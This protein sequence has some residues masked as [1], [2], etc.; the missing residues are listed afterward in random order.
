N[1]IDYDAFG[2]ILAQSDANVVTVAYYTGRYRDLVTGLQYDRARWYHADTGRW[3]SEDPI[4]F[5]AG[6]ANLYRYVGNRPVFN[7]DPRGL[8]EPSW[9]SWIRMRSSAGNIRIMRRWYKWHEVH[10]FWE[11]NPEDEGWKGV[12][13]PGYVRRQYHADRAADY[14][15]LVR[16]EYDLTIGFMGYDKA[17]GKGQSGK[18]HL[19]GVFSFEGWRNLTSDLI[20][21]YQNL[22]EEEDKNLLVGKP[23]RKTYYLQQACKRCAST[24][25]GGAK[26]QQSFFTSDPID[27]PGKLAIGEIGGITCE[28]IDNY[29]DELKNA[30]AQ[31]NKDFN[32][33]VCE[34]GEKGSGPE[35]LLK[36]GDKLPGKYALPNWSTM[37][38]ATW[39]NYPYLPW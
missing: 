31:A 39:W 2:R 33:H 38:E 17:K 12:L 21:K 30:V 26:W 9:S 25:D 34:H 22:S 1:H 20:K 14:D 28:I 8:A 5:K 32:N 29:E 6:D 18:L 24:D 16:H 13:Q 37:E 3:L 35:M 7:I 27:L 4:G 11:K 19:P 23:C 15:V 36:L 10:V